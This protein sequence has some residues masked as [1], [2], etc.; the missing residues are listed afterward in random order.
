LPGRAPRR[1][2]EAPR[3]EALP[4]KRS[5]PGWSRPEA[6]AARCRS[7]NRA[8]TSKQRTSLHHPKAR[9]EGP[10]QRRCLLREGSRFGFRPGSTR[11]Q[12]AAAELCL[13]D[14][15]GELSLIF[16]QIEAQHLLRFPIAR[17]HLHI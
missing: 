4:A 12:E 16:R 15:A 11:R 6:R 2:V 13:A 3:G 10:I 1:T 5:L 7:E 14:P 17:F 9:A 8:A